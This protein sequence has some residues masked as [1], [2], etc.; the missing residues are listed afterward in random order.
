MTLGR[1]WQGEDP[2]GWFVSEKL[3]G[4]R[5]YWDGARLWTRGGHVINAPSW[6]TRKLPSGVHLDGEIFAG[7]GRFEE[8]RLAVQYGRWTRRCRFVA[9]DC[10]SASGTWA[11][12]MAVADSQY[13]DVVA[14]KVCQ[15]R[16][17]LIADLNR[18]QLRGGEG[19]VIRNPRTDRYE[20]GRT[21]NTLKVKYVVAI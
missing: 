12:R 9:F 15:D 19:L 1:D 10:P 20:V 4:C 7:R 13:G 5:A 14:V 11:K 18:V 21:T 3:D 6:F 17:S 16:S 2:S 8:A